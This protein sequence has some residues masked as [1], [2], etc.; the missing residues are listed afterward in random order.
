MYQVPPVLLE[1][2]SSTTATLQGSELRTEIVSNVDLNQERSVLDEPEKD[3]SAYVCDIPA[4]IQML[5]EKEDEKEDPGQPKPV[6]VHSVV[7]QHSASPM[8]DKTRR[9]EAEETCEQSGDESRTIPAQIQMEAFSP[10]QP[11]AMPSHAKC[12]MHRADR[13]APSSRAQGKC[14]DEGGGSDLD[15]D[16]GGPHRSQVL[17]RTVLPLEELKAGAKGRKERRTGEEGRQGAVSY[18]HLTLPTIC[19]V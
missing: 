12:M 19:S 1:T 18:T 6:P 9:N 16:N 8:P 14:T 13:K 7:L 10:H 5:A 17:L 3:A 11:G 15:E 4:Q 2:D